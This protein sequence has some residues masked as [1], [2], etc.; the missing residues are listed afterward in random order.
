MRFLDKLERKLGFL[1]I[2]NL[3][4]YLVVGQALAFIMIRIRPEAYSLMVFN[5]DR[6]ISGEVWRIFSFMLIP[7]DFSLIFIIFTLLILQMMGSAL[8]QHWGAFRYNLYLLVGVL[9]VL[10][11]GM[12]FP[13]HV[14]DSFYVLLSISFAFAYLYPNFELNLFFVLPVKMKWI[15]LMLLGYALY[16]FANPSAVSQY[17]AMANRVE[18]I[19][20]LINFPLFFGADIIRSMRSKKRVREM[21]AEKRKFEAEPFHTCIRCGATDLSH[22]DREFRYRDE[23]AICSV[24]LENENREQKQEGPR[25]NDTSDARA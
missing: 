14:I 25:P 17:Q 22:P 24:C 11:A 16:D 12:V 5:F 2:H 6:F 19:G 7:R 10:I 13:Q 4:L 9:G 8:E 15:A 1:A 3:T 20:A 23:G 18:I 21:K